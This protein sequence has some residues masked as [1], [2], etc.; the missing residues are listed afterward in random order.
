MDAAADSRRY[1]P[2]RSC[3]SHP[4]ALR[5]GSASREAAVAMADSTIDR[6][7]SRRIVSGMTLAFRDPNAC[8]SRI[9]SG[10]HHVVR[11]LRA[12]GNEASW[13]L[14]GLTRSGLS[15]PRIPLCSTEGSADPCRSDDPGPCAPGLHFS[16][17]FQARESASTTDPPLSTTTTEALWNTYCRRRPE[18]EKD[19]SEHPACAAPAAMVE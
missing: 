14:V 5:S 10:N 18:Q 7:T 2:P 12:G 15:S 11:L 16:I 1:V 9:R 3:S 4:S 19:P 17:G 13:R 8:A 6:R